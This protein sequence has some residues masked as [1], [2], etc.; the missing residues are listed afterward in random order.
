MALILTVKAWENK[1]K[2]F[3]P[4]A[5]NLSAGLWAICVNGE[6]SESRL[7]ESGGN[8]A[9]EVEVGTEELDVVFNEFL[10]V[11]KGRD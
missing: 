2:K 7:V 8:I 11:C 9:V 4:I 6:L 5:Q 3:Q 1:R 10:R